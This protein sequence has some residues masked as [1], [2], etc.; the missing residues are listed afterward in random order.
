MPDGGVTSY[1]YD[2]AGQ[3]RTIEDP[4]GGVTTLTYDDQP[5]LAT[6]VETRD[7]IAATAARRCERAGSPERSHGSTA[8]R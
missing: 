5:G 6:E 7:Q 4:A 2:A 1:D 8:G 3:L